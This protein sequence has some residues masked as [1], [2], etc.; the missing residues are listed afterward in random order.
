MQTTIA[1][2]GPIGTYSETAALRFAAAQP[3][4]PV[5]RPYANITQTLTAVVERQV[6]LAVVPIENSVEGGVIMTLDT[7]WQLEQLQVQQALILPIRHAL[8]TRA[9]SLDAI[10]R[11]YS[12]PQ[13]IAQCQRWLAQNLPQVALIPANSTTENLKDVAQ[14]PTAAAISSARAAE[15]YDLPILVSPIND[16]P[17][18]CTRFLLLGLEPSPGGSITSLAFSLL[19][20]QPGTLVDMLH[21][22]ADRNI[23]LSR[24]ESRP[25]KRSMGDYLFFVDLEA[26]ARDVLTQAALTDL[27]AH[28]ETLKI[29][30]SYDLLPD[31]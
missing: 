12:H 20:N 4:A 6:Q 22:F 7:L 30:G 2:L 9:P 5:L 14:D 28:T 3:G 16:H 31:R 19:A 18:N 27:A 10:R 8:L 23:N 17:D 25:T 15:L 21:I 24:I 11:I 13:G 26:D 1:H 29:F